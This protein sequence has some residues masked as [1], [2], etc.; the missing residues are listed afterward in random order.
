MSQPAARPS[1]GRDPCPL[2]AEEQAIV[3]RVS[4]VFRTSG[5]KAAVVVFSFPV[6]DA[7]LQCLSREHRITHVISQPSPGVRHVRSLGRSTFPFRTA[8]VFWSEDIAGL[9]WLLLLLRCG[10]I[11]VV[12]ISRHPLKSETASAAR[13][14]ARGIMNGLEDRALRLIAMSGNAA[15]RRV[16]ERVAGAPISRLKLS[17]CSI[18]HTQT[19]GPIIYAT[20]SLGAGGSERQLMLTAKGVYSRCARRVSVICQ[21]PL[22]GKN[23]FFASELENVG[24]SIEDQSS[25]R[26]GS[27]HTESLQAGFDDDLVRSA[28]PR[29]PQLAELVLFFANRFS[30]ERPAIV[31]AW[32]DETNIAAGIAAAMA[33][34][35]KI[36]LGCRS[37]SPLNFQFY[38]PYM[39]QGYRQL[40]QLPQVVILNNSIAGARDYARWLQIRSER[41]KVI[42]NGLEFSSVGRPFPLDGSGGSAQSGKRIVGMVGRIAEEK[43]PYLWLEIASEILNMRSDVHFVWAGDGPMRKDVER[44]AEQLGI[45]AH[46]SLLG[47]VSDVSTV[48]ASMA[49][50]LLTSRVE[51]LPNVSIE[52]QH[53]GVPAVV[54]AVG[55]AAETINEGVTGVSVA[56]DDAQAFAKAVLQFLDSPEALARSRS[57]GPSFVQ[58]RFSVERMIAATMG[59]Y[60][61]EAGTS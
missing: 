23:R 39:W 24:I 12:K 27:D 14:L 48:W 57:L 36:V 53:F 56:G 38:Q 18:S 22:V 43:R 28:F 46:L 58:G 6:S 54:A 41:I 13:Y 31:H 33:G 37:L 10:A 2:A 19:D 32:L 59:V 5:S 4:E 25:I 60:E 47:L 7:L 30:I 11:R 34:V 21:S 61:L 16:A 15:A 49:V 42:P 52:A 44:R 51:G 17:N 20:G 8:L 40:A 35:P 55:G 9:R 50:F 29:N 45:S 26:Q 3:H 1:E